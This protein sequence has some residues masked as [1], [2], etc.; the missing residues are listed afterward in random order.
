MPRE[1]RESWDLCRNPLYDVVS[2]LL[3]E[4]E[5]ADG[6][7]CRLERNGTRY[8]AAGKAYS[9]TPRGR[10]REVPANQG[11]TAIIT[12]FVPEL[13]QSYLPGSRW[14]G[15]SC[16]LFIPKSDEEKKSTGAL[17]PRERR[18]SWNLCRNPLYDVV[19]ELLTEFESDGGS[20]SRLERNG[21]RYRAAGK[22]IPYPARPESRGSSE[23]G[24][25][26]ERPL[27]S[28]MPT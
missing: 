12:P 28:L 13:R 15:F 22:V 20:I 19:S 5:T 8:R 2:E 16:Y 14:R 11:G 26:R 1:Q 21:T 17:M 23:L 25:Y 4:I 27:S 24:W 18:E 3:T 7:I 9:L 6:S 10:N